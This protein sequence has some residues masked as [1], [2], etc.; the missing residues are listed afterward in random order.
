VTRKLPKKVT[1]KQ[2]KKAKRPP[3][4][5]RKRP[6]KRKPSRTSLTLTCAVTTI[7]DV[8]ISFPS[9]DEENWRI[10]NG[11]EVARAQA[12]D[13]V[14]KIRARMRARA[15][16]AGRIAELEEEAEDSPEEFTR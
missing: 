11:V 13:L 10:E 7:V 6:K 1:R 2:R 14:E 3:T 5:K 16:L 15:L 8:V 12:H 9:D 4:K